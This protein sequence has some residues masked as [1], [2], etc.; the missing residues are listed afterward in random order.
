MPPKENHNPNPKPP[1]G[2]E[3]LREF[4]ALYHARQGHPYPVSWAKHG[5][6]IKRLVGLYPPE[7]IRRLFDRLLADTDEFVRASGRRLEVLNS[8]IP[9]YL[10][11]IK[12]EGE[13]INEVSDFERVKEFLK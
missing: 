12:R 3:L 13:N 1:S 4:L 8:Q 10:E 6:I 9:R 11:E 5:A 7:L 2:R